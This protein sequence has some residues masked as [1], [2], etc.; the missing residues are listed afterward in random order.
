MP[1]EKEKTYYLVT[2][3]DHEKLTKEDTLTL[4]VKSIG[5]STLG[6][7]FISLSDFVFEDHGPIVDPKFETLKK[8]FEK[9]KSLHLSLYSIVS[10]EEVGQDHPGLAFQ[11]DKSNLLSFVPSPERPN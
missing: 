4:K 3:R 1:M 8:R 2:F 7:G 11:K 10:V 6:L 9:T 5:D